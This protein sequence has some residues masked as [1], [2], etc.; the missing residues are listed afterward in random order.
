MEELIQ[1]AKNGDKEAFTTIMLSLEKDLYKIAKTRLKNDD[2]IY[3]AIQETIIEAFKSIKK[4]KNTEAFK[5]WIIRILINKTNDIFRRKKHKKEILLEDIKNTETKSKRGTVYAHS[6]ERFQ[7]D[8]FKNRTEKNG[9]HVEDRDLAIVQS[10]WVQFTKR[11]EGNRV[12]FIS[13]TY[14]GI[15]TVMDKDAFVRVLT[16]GIGREKAY[17][18]GMLTV[19]RV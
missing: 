4:L 5:T 17:G 3:D 7:R 6:V 10:Q 19:M 11:Q 15:L 13:V 9:F 18:M 16:E 8:W 1:K 12:S 14:E 2:D